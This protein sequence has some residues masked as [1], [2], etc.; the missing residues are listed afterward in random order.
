[1]K[2]GDKFPVTIEGHVVAMASV[3]DIED[4]KATL[5]IPTTVAIFG[6]R[7][8]LTDLPGSA[9]EDKT[10]TIID[11]VERTNAEVT[12]ESTTNSTT[13]TNPGNESTSTETQASEIK[14]PEQPTAPVQQVQDTSSNV[15][16]AQ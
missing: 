10:Q 4:G 14:P 3:R 11:G 15:E 5:V 13:E 2:R 1:M 6:V 9:T 8:S 16:E 12:N 7:T